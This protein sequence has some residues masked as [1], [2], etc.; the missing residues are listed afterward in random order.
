MEPVMTPTKHVTRLLPAVFAGFALMVIWTGVSA[1]A[2][3][4]EP[5]PADRGQ[6]AHFYRRRNPFMLR[7]NVPADWGKKE[8]VWT[9][10]AKG[11][12]EKARATLIPVWQIDEAVIRGN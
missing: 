2:N 12:T 6:P 4:F 8:L 3:F 7:V 11:K 5:G 10:I 1:Q 9:L